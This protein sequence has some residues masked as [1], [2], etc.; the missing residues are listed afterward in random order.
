MKAKFVNEKFT[1]DSDPI[2]DM[3][4]GLWNNG[5]LID[6]FRE[7]RLDWYKFLS[8]LLNGKTITATLQRYPS[9]T[10]K[11]GTIKVKNVIKSDFEDFFVKAEN[12]GRYRISPDK[13]IKIKY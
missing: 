7:H 11:E 1:E 8:T 5:R 10:V 3:H 4:I 12:G 2:S 9:M 6:L 13:N